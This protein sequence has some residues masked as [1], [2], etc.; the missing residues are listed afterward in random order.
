MFIKAISNVCCPFTQLLEYIN[1]V[2]ESIKTNNLSLIILVFENMFKNCFITK[3]NQQFKGKEFKTLDIFKDNLK[4]IFGKLLLNIC[5]LYNITLLI[6]Y[7]IQIYRQIPI[8]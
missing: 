2:Q 3:E 5:I 1:D 7:F 4:L 8:I 6:C